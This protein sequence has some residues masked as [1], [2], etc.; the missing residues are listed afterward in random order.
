MLQPTNDDL[1]FG[2]SDLIEYFNFLSIMTQA[3][4]VEGHLCTEVIMFCSSATDRLLIACRT[5]VMDTHG[6]Q[7]T[8]VSTYHVHKQLIYAYF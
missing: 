7:D 1:R 2:V 4:R 5:Q 8:M 3:Q 6:F